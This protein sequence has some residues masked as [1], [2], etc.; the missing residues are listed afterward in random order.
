MSEKNINQKAMDT[1][2]H[3]DWDGAQRL[4]REA[5]ATYNGY[6]SYNN[7]GIYYIHENVI[8]KNSKIINGRALGKRWLKKSLSVKETPKALNNLALIE[9]ETDHLSEAYTYWERAYQL[10][11]DPNTSYNIAATL[12]RMGAYAQAAERARDRSLPEAKQLYVC[13]LCM[14]DPAH[15]LAM[16]RQGTLS[17]DVVDEH[18]A[19]YL[20]HKMNQYDDVIRIAEEFDKHNIGLNDNQVLLLWNS[21]I[22][23]GRKD[24]GIACIKQRY[25]EGYDPSYA[26]SLWR[27]LLKFSRD[28]MYRAQILEKCLIYPQPYAPE[29]EFFGCPMHG[30]PWD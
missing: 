22:Q 9:Y 24:E 11:H 10:T 23:S 6:R 2:A 29:C 20:Y 27:Q 18:D 1:L 3:Q 12:F 15:S 4:F 7:L 25:V 13:A 21:Y 14:N 16:I 26:R 5:C 8:C 17:L 30:T 28:P 19:M